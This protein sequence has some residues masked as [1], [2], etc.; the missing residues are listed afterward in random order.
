MYF[1]SFVVGFFAGFNYA[2][3]GFNQDTDSWGGQ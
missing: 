2:K 1:G 3:S